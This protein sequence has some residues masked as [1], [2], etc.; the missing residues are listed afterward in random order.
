MRGAREKDLL[1]VGD[2]CEALGRSKARDHDGKGL[3]IALL[4]AAERSDGFRILGVT[5]KVKAAEPL[6]RNDPA[7]PRA[8][9]VSR[10][11][12]PRPPYR[13]ASRA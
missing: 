1:I 4:A 11:A 5:R 2:V 3:F 10:M 9:T 8:F 7:A 6:D 12:S 13:R